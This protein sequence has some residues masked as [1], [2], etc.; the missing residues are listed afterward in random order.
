MNDSP[1]GARARL[2]A[3]GRA[4]RIRSKSSWLGR[5]PN[6]D[7]D[8]D[9]RAARVW[10]RSA[11]FLSSI[12]VRVAGFRS[13]EYALLRACARFVEATLDPA[14]WELRGGRTNR[15]GFAKKKMVAVVVLVVIAAVLI[16]ALA[17]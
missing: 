17:A 7:D 13:N 16:Y 6:V 10:S 3:T 4:W 2:T 11:G 8:A 5:N 15:E 14:P 9:G 12:V 1:P